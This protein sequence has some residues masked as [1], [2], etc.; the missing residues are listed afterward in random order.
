M[1][2]ISNWLAR[3][4]WFFMIQWMRQPWMRRAQLAPLKWIPEHKHEKFMTSHKS[5]NRF[6]RRIGLPL[7]KTMYFILVASFVLQIFFQLAMR[8][9]EAGY[10]N[11]PKTERTMDE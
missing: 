11:A 6:A 4:T 3:K 9:S 8:M 5:Q 1:S 7:M 2:F 10:F